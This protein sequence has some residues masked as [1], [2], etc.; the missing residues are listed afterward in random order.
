MRST[1]KASRAGDSTAAVVT[2]CGQREAVGIAGVSTAARGGGP[3]RAAD[4][5][6]EL[7][8][9]GVGPIRATAS[10]P[11]C[12]TSAAADEPA[13][14]HLQA[15]CES[16]PG[17]LAD[18]QRERRSHAIESDTAFDDRSASL[19]AHNGPILHRDP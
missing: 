18:H 17:P 14:E 10:P 2:D 16:R 11:G 7:D 12:R 3:A 5:N 4:A 15:I 1:T 13:S 8:G 19:D 6:P 9:P